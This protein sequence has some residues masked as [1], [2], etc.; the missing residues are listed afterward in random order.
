MNKKPWIYALGLLV[1]ASLACNFISGAGKKEATP[2]SGAGKPLVT[3]AAGTDDTTEVPNIVPSTA[4]APA[5]GEAGTGTNSNTTEFPL[6]TDITNFVDLGDGWINFQANMSVKD[7][8]A[9]YR[10]SFARQGYK[11]REVNTAITDTTF[12]LVFDG[13]ASGKAIVVQGVDVG[14]AV[15]VNIRFED[16]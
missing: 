5:T 12:S 14:G 9:F 4:E 16:L 3:A 13:H 11:E 1:I 2:Q 8:I 15:N 7:A 6:P 10:D